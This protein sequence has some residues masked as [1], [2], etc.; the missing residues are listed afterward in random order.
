MRL[1]RLSVVP[2][3]L[4]L[5]LVVA[6]AGSVAAASATATTVRDTCTLTGGAWGQGY[7]ALRVRATEHGLPG[8]ARIR[9][10]ASLMH[11]PRFNSASWTLHQTQ[12]HVS[13][14][15]PANGAAHSRAWTAAWN[16]GGDTAAYRHRIDVTVWFLNAAGGVLA[17]RG[18]LGS[19]C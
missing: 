5:S 9:F 3:V 11:Q 14:A 4:A 15:I 18:V 1:M 7:I 2:A 8:V 12:Q 17:T 13:T 10:V 6:L 19:T 16:F